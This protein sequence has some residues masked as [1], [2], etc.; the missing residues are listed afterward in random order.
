MN[1]GKGSTPLHY[2]NLMSKK[3]ILTLKKQR[4]KTKEPESLI[5]SAKVKGK[6]CRKEL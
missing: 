4:G 3:N 1:F 6:T 2:L 5:I